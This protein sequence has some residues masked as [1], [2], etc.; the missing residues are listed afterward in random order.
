MHALDALGNEVRRE[1]LVRLRER[2]R[3][4]RELAEGFPVSRPAISRHLRLLEEAGLV[5]GRPSGARKVYAL[6][7]AGFQPAQ[8]YLAQFWDESLANL[9]RLVAE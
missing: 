6:R 8:A 7:W 1:M 4:V 5:Q 9:E 3:S 2:P